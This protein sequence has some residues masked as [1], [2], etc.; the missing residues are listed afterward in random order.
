MK[1]LFRPAVLLVAILALP[2]TGYPQ[3]GGPNPGSAFD[4][5][6]TKLFGDIKGFSAKS[7][8]A[9]KEAKGVTTLAANFAMLDD[10]IRMDMDLGQIKGPDVPPDMAAQLKGMGMDK[11]STI[12]DTKAKRVQLIYPTAKAYADMP[13]PQEQAAALEKEPKMER[14][15]LGEEKVEGH[16]CIKYRYTFEDD[17]GKKREALVWQAAKLKDFPVKIQTTEKGNEITILY[18]DIKLDRPAASQFAVPDDFTK[19][20]GMMEL[21]QGVMMKQMQVPR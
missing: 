14:T 9:L 12:V 8:I 13:L 19:Y 20:A 11:I 16:D 1:N 10:K 18:K 5:A 7:D 2:L 15:K 21:M 4:V 17:Q 3:I 6:F